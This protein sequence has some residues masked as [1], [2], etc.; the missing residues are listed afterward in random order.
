[1][2]MDWADGAKYDDYR[3]FAILGSP[4]FHAG[5]KDGY[6]WLPKTQSERETRKSC[7]HADTLCRR[8]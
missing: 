8:N 2:A 3:G 1:M 5:E 4:G 6:L 7:L